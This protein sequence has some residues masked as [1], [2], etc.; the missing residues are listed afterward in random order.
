MMDDLEARPSSDRFTL[1][2]ERH[3]FSGYGLK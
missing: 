3:V 2:Q 1:S